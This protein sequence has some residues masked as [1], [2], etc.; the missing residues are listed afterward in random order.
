[1]SAEDHRS[2][3]AHPDVVRHPHGDPAEQGTQL[4]PVLDRPRSAARGC[5]TPTRRRR[6]RECRC[7]DTAHRRPA[8][9]RPGR[10]PSAGPGSASAAAPGA[11]T[12]AVGPGSSAGRSRV[13]GSRSLRVR[14]AQHWAARS[15][16]S[17]RVSTPSA[18]ARCSRAS[19]SRRSRS[20]IRM[21]GC[22]SSTAPWWQ[23]RGGRGRGHRRVRW[24][25]GATGVRRIA[26][27]SGGRRRAEQRRGDQPG[28]QPPVRPGE[29]RRHRRDGAAQVVATGQVGPAVPLRAAR[30][31]PRRTPAPG[32]GASAAG[33][34]ARS[35]GTG[36]R[37]ARRPARA[38]R[39]PRPAPGRRRRAAGWPG[40]APPRG[41]RF[42]RGGQAEPAGRVDQGAAAPKPSTPRPRCRGVSSRN[43]T[44]SS[45]AAAGGVD[46]VP[47]Q[48]GQQP[49]AQHRHRTGR[50]GAASEVSS[51][52][53]ASAP[54]GTA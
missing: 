44:R 23:L 4:E 26:V 29:Q 52:S 21:S 8:P 30:R 46:A 34:P 17:L 14:A 19:T 5:R 20:P 37:P 22:S 54:S 15:S 45:G 1:M 12:S 36:A 6:P 42:E 11:G 2:G 40:R 35:G 18:W 13:S 49:A 31:T 39:R 9:R 28:A 32:A 47:G 33:P 48:P 16:Y 50:A 7:P 51:S 3:G 10:P 53:T 43:S 41:A 27:R 38:P 24:R 25:S